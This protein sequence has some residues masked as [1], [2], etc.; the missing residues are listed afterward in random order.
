MPRKARIDAPGALHHI[1]ARGID[2]RSIFEDDTDRNDF[3]PRRHI[4]ARIGTI[5]L[6][7]S[8]AFW[9]CQGYWKVAPLPILWTQCFAWQI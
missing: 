8:T 4:P 9:Y 3:M 7:K 2:R 5:R 6:L 1:I